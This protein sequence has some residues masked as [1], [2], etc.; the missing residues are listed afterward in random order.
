MGTDLNKSLSNYAPKLVHDVSR[1]VCHRDVW[2]DICVQRPLWTKIVLKHRSQHGHARRS[3]Y[4][5]DVVD[6]FSCHDLVVKCNLDRAQRSR[7]EVFAGLLELFAGHR[8]V[9]SRTV[10][11]QA[12]RLYGL[13][14]TQVAL[15]LLRKLEQPFSGA[16]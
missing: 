10:R 1:P 15:D 14:V 8:H 9:S 12:L 4:Q 11:G 5:Y 3:T 16:R 6:V 2:V 13:L 7:E